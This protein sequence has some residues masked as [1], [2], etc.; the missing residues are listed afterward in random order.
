MQLQLGS[1][2]IDRA[3][4][5][6]GLL[7]RWNRRFRLVGFRQPETMVSQVLLDSFAMLGYLPAR[8]RILD[9][10]SGAGI[11]GIPLALACPDRQL[12]LLDRAPKRVRF[13]QWAGQQLGLDNLRAVQADLR[14]WRPDGPV[15][16][17]LAR[18]VMPLSQLLPAARRLC[19]AGTALLLQKGPHWQ[20]EL[21]SGW[22]GFALI[23]QHCYRVPGIPTP[24]YL[25]HL[26]A[27]AESF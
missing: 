13:T 8:S 5:F 14:S 7:Q 25:L 11:P 15:D 26:E 16:I 23:H 3:V 19:S 24:R 4:D 6:L 2:L 22:S 17:L 20:T 27:T 9:L 18:A 21:S 10:G 1:E 12:C